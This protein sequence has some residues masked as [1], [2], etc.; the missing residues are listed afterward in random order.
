MTTA[1]TLH[2]VLPIPGGTIT[3]DTEGRKPFDPDAARAAAAGA[4]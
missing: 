1:L 3:V 2:L 4:L